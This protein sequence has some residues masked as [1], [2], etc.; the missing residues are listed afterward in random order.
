MLSSQVRG[1]SGTRSRNGSLLMSIDDEPMELSPLLRNSSVSASSTPV[2]A[3]LAAV[4]WEIPAHNTHNTH[5]THTHNITTRPAP[6]TALLP[7]AS[8]R[9]RVERARRDRPVTGSTRTAR[10]YRTTPTP[11]SVGASLV[12]GRHA[13]AASSRVTESPARRRLFAVASAADGLGAV[14]SR[15]RVDGDGSWLLLPP[16]LRAP[17]LNRL[18]LSNAI[19]PPDEV[20]PR[21]TKLGSWAGKPRPLR[22]SA[23]ARRATHMTTSYAGLLALT[24]DSKLFCSAHLRRNGGHLHVGVR[25]KV[26]VRAK[27]GLGL[28]LGYLAC[29]DLPPSSP[30]PRRQCFLESCTYESLTC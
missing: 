16:A 7:L 5:N 3:G 19:H 15:P 1:P 17:R 10:A 25:A 6:T 8:A 24:S 9:E 12:H 20:R 27:V 21:M 26:R 18:T 29:S 2:A 14:G 22:P 4:A 23:V 30:T 13:A 11:T 28:G